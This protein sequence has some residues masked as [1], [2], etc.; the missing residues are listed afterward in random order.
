MG[1]EHRK[2]KS[3][4][5][6][7]TGELGKL[8]RAAADDVIAL[9]PEA[10]KTTEME[11]GQ[12]RALLAGGGAV[13]TEIRPAPALPTSRGAELY[14][15]EATTALAPATQLAHGSSPD[16]AALQLPAPLA[17]TLH[18]HAS[19]AYPTA[20]RSADRWITVLLGALIFGV[21]GVI[22]VLAIL[23]FRG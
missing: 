21:V 1:S 4:G 2:E 17:P 22:A 11:P 16:V 9:E 14:P 5:R 23:G 15:R 3:T 12:F 6:I 10:R 19:P 18:G 20:P 7:A 8:T 13:R